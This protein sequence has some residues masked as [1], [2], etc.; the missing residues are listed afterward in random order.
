MR[1]KNTK[2]QKILFIK[3]NGFSG[4][5]ILSGKVILECNLRDCLR[6]TDWHEDRLQITKTRVSSDVDVPS[7]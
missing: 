6:R 4:D 2:A 1:Q 7:S 5:Q 3:Y